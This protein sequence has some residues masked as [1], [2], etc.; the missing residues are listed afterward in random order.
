[1]LY[2]T[3]AC[4]Y[5]YIQFLVLPSLVLLHYCTLFYC[6]LW[7]NDEFDGIW[8][9]CGLR[10][11]FR[12]GYGG[13]GFYDHSDIMTKL[14]WSCCNFCGSVAL[15]VWFTRNGMCVKTNTIVYVARA[16]NSKRLRA[17][18]LLLLAATVR[19]FAHMPLRISDR[20]S[21]STKVVILSGVYC[22]R[23]WIAP[24]KT[25]FN[26]GQKD[27]LWWWRKG[28]S[29]INWGLNAIIWARWPHRDTNQKLCARWSRPHYATAV[30]P[31]IFA[32]LSET[33]KQEVG[34]I[35]NDVA[36]T[37]I[38]DTSVATMKCF[39]KRK[40]GHRFSFENLFYFHILSYIY[41]R[42]SLHFNLK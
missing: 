19:S 16:S 12:C 8:A 38:S 6:R 5:Y 28:R 32:R 4:R 1:M 9:S 35:V 26:D 15:I 23:L 2:C 39:F 18:S 27:G 13:F 24:S 17:W 40:A 37:F 31:S 33:L 30:S 7:L 3:T 42:W 25:D 20:N 22:I 11:R 10:R 29:T 34:Q 21:P 14:V 41:W 36:M